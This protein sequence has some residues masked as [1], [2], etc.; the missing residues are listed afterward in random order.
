VKRSVLALLFLS[1]CALYEPAP[2]PPERPTPPTTCHRTFYASPE[3]TME[4]RIGLERAA[5]R[6]NAIATEQFCIVDGNG[7]WASHTINRV[8]YGG[9]HWRS[10]SDQFHGVDWLGV[11][12][13]SNDSIGIV[14]GLG[15][16]MFEVVSLH[17]LGHAH[18]LG[19]TPPP[20]VMHA[21]AGTALDFTGND[22]AECARVGAC[23]SGDASAPV[24]LEHSDEVNILTIL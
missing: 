12:Y 21:S 5:M 20:S 11:H 15:F 7:S 16:E 24:V 10:V 9:E 23:L 4:E 6:W 1:A 8:E 19:H 14:S 13:G 22:L 3:F 17:E 2:T 18:G